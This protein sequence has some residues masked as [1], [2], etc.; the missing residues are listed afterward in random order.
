MFRYSHTVLPAAVLLFAVVAGGC[1]TGDEAGAPEV[2]PE[3]AD[4]VDEIE[5]ARQQGE[6][7]RALSLADTLARRPDAAAHAHFLRGDILTDLNYFDSARVAFEKVLELDDQYSGARFKLGHNAFLRQ[8]YTEAIGHYQEE[9]A[10]MQRGAPMRDGGS[11]SR[12][13]AN[14]SAQI[15]RSHALLGESDSA[16]VYYEDALA[17]DSLNA[18]A[19]VWRGRMYEEEGEYEQ[20]IAL[21]RRAVAREPRDPDYRFRLGSALLAAGVLEVWPVRGNAPAPT[22]ED[23]PAGK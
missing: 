20:A 23:L 1:A 14:V 5:T 12:N 2:S 19:A 3:A 8:Q 13:L 21:Y 22:R 15:G 10:V 11:I 16:R 6:F 7:G 18:S 4:L 17:H 9:R